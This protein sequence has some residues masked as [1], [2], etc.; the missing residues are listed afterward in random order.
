MFSSVVGVSSNPASQLDLT[1]GHANATLSHVEFTH[2]V[3]EPEHGN[4]GPDGH[5]A[6]RESNGTGLE[7]QV[8]NGEVGDRENQSSFGEEAEVSPLV[9]HTLL[10][11]R[12]STG[13][14]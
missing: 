10:S 7:D 13:L 2:L 1:G 5:T 9:S 3:V 11:H 12:K 14:G 6:V 8:Q 4:P